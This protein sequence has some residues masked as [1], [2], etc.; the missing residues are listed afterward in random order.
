M[1]PHDPPADILLAR[2]CLRGHVYLVGQG[3]GPGEA[4]GNGVSLL[5]ILCS[6]ESRELC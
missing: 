5:V 2:T 1:L 3:D 4:P 6:T